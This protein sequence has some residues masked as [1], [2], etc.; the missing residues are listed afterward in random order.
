M[1]YLVAPYTFVD[2]ECFQSAT[3]EEVLEY[4]EN[5]EVISVDT[6]T[7]GRDPHTKKILSLQ[8]GDFENQFVIDVRHTNIL[9]FKD[10]LETKTCIF[11]NAKFDYKFLKKAGIIVEHIIDIM[12]AECVIYAGY[13]KWGY[14]LDKLAKRYLNIDLDKSTRGDFFKLKDEPFNEYQITY[15]ANDVKILEPIWIKQRELL[16]KY[17]LTY[18]ALLEFDVVKALG[19]IEY[20][21]IAF[22]KKA[23]LANTA[24][25]QSRLIIIENELDILVSTTPELQKFVPKYVQTNLFDF[26]ERSINLNYAS[27]SQMKEVVRA[28]NL[29]IINTNEKELEKVSHIPFV[30]KLLEYRKEAKIVSTYGEAFLN[31]INPKTKRIHTSFWQ[32]VSTGR[33][34]SGSKDDTAPNLQNIPASNS[35]RNCFTASPGYLWVGCDY[36]GQELALMADGSGEKGFIDVLNKGEDL[37]CFAG[38]M[39]FGR[40]ITKADKEDRQKAKTINFGKP[41]GMGPSKFANTLGCS[42]EEADKLFKLYAKSF[43]DLNKWLDSQSKLAKSRG[44]SE[45]FSPC[46]RKRWYPKIHQ[47]RRLREQEDKDWKAILTI[48]GEIE[49]NG[50]NHPIQGS[51]ADICKEALVEVRK[52]ILALNKQHNKEV[53]RL[54]CT[55][56]DAIDTEV[57]EEFAEEFA[58]E[59]E[60]IMIECGNKYVTKVSMK[61]DTTITKVWQK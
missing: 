7:R 24:I 1:I 37:H 12:L 59:K 31:Y 49:R 9:L 41:Y 5:H 53:A 40:T 51:G 14:G 16:E 18:T 36:S 60:R 33:I 11:Q 61:V 25:H 42:L 20:N 29:Y 58:K 34:S 44:Y 46:K 21:G 10:L 17:G 57:L 26:E 39:M 28:L 23:W 3:V 22:N 6:E 50:S 2:K 54:L 8:L 13:E 15:A 48:E 47:A 45:T 30:A 56:H 43:P 35:F 52:Y 19:D 38:S 55:V 4:F 32:I 27:P